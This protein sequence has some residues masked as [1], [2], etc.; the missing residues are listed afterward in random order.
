MS[1]LFA[2]IALAL[3][4]PT[5]SHPCSLPSDERAWIESAIGKWERVRETQLM[6][7]AA[8]LPR[9]VFFDGRCVWEG[10]SADDLAGRGHGGTIAIPGGGEAP[11]RPMAFAG[12]NGGQGPFLVMALPPLWRETERYANHPRLEVL[13]RSVF[14]HE[15]THTRQADS[16]G[17]RLDAIETSGELQSELDDDIVQRRFEPDETYRASY[18]KERD[19]LFAIAQEPNAA[20]RLAAARSVLHEAEKRRLKFFQGTASVYG[21][22]EEIFLAMEGVANWAGFRAAMLEGLPREEAIELMRGSRRPWTQE[23]G[24][25]L[26]L[27]VDALMPGWQER[28]FSDDPDGAWELLAAALSS[29]ASVSHR[30]VA[31]RGERELRAG[32]LQRRRDPAPGP[33]TVPSLT[34]GGSPPRTRRPGWGG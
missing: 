20:R 10:R 27:A 2:A 5:S 29:A 24:L 7:P 3:A 22:L 31:A 4:S 9:F 30:T 19:A 33:P 11:A 16:F 34:G 21:E 6:L 28:A 15:M 13:M 14:V 32:A 8:P 25:A 17:Q 26:F 1:P 18:E 12:R 23:E